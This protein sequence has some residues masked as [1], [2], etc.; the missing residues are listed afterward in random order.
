MTSLAA[1]ATGGQA[2]PAIPRAAALYLAVVQLLFTTMWTV[3]AIFL[4]ALAEAAGLSRDS[5]SGILM[6]DQV[7]FLVM[8]VAM[9]LA[10][11]CLIRLY[12]RLAAP[13][14]AATTISCVAFLLI[15]QVVERGD[16]GPGVRVL[17]I[18][19][20]A[21]WSITSS[22]LRAPPWVL[23]ARYAAAP[24]VPWL[25]A[26]TLV[27]VSVAGAVAPYLGVA[28]RNLDPRLPFAL[29]SVTLLAVTGGLIGVERLL[30]RAGQ[31]TD[32]P[33]APGVPATLPLARLALTPIFVGAMGC[34]AL[35]FQA[36][37]AINSVPQ[38]LRFASQSDLEY[39]LPIFWIGFNLC[40]FPAA[41]LTT[42]AGG[43]AVMAWAGALGAGGLLRAAL[44]P[45]L[46]LTILGQLVAGGAWGAVL[47]AGLASAV[48]LGRVGR[49]GF[50]LG[51][52][53]AVQALATLIRMA[54]IAAN[55]NK[56]PDFLALSVWA[57]PV[58][59]VA[60]ALLLAVAIGRAVARRAPL[61]ARA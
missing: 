23:L 57:P 18:G 12:R 1:S 44:A 13:I 14:V 33:A 40:S 2:S 47:T 21:V 30:A 43:L 25:A 26:L 19:L 54:V 36:H 39:L 61:P 52:W 22:A 50:T 10:A 8:D 35:G 32:A 16:G 58:L 20:I 5:V 60:G 29:S 49:E 7:L 9:G 46:G 37:S 48:A 38:Y 51:L 28:L 56:A 41:G 55:A 11:D 42:R 4:P 24:T 17:L 27:G 45:N 34:L 15:P 59:W 6:F 53:F 3:Y 31:S